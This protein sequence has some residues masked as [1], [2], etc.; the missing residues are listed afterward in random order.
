MSGQVN[1][2][3][4]HNKKTRRDGAFE[5]CVLC[6]KLLAAQPKY[7]ADVDTAEFRSGFEIDVIHAAGFGAVVFVTKYEMV[8]TFHL[9]AEVSECEHH[10]RSRR[11]TEVAVFG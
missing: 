10:T 7:E 6:I 5:I 8:D 1:A 11:G 3:F 2:G 4:D 9:N